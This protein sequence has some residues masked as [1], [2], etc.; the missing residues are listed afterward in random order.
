MNA[1]LAVSDVTILDSLRHT[2]AV[3]KAVADR[4]AAVVADRRKL[5]EQLV[6]IEDGAPARRYLAAVKKHEQTIEEAKIVGAAFQAAEQKVAEA[7][8]ARVTA[9]MAIRQGRE[10]VLAALHA[11]ADNA[12]I[13]GFIRW[14]RDE[15][16][17]TRK[18]VETREIVHESRI[19]GT[20]AIR[21]VGNAE[22]VAARVLALNEAI[23]VA[24]DLRIE[25]DQS[26]VPGRIAALKDALPPPVASP[27]SSGKDA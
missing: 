20:K 14:A 24:E 12:T 10:E 3:T 18:A 19:T 16:D 7:E 1:K 6:E 17:S 15:M 4:A 8:T 26:A 13:D 11:G 21:Y 27:A 22:A 5:R 2:P 25:A 9:S 23:S